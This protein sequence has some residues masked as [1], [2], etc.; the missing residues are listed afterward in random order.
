MYNI[1]SLLQQNK[2]I[3]VLVLIII[4]DILVG[5]FKSIKQ[6]KFNA[7]DGIDGATRKA[8]ELI[9]IVIFIFIDGLFDFN[10]IKFTGLDI[11]SVI[12][13]NKLGLAEFFSIMFTAYELTSVL[14]NLALCGVWLP[15]KVKNSIYEWVENITGEKLTDD[16][17]NKK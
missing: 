17:I 4:L 15:S 6:K 12:G 7:Q 3:S 16:N 5:T 10:L 11:L 2:I 14:K 9:T 8:V 13:I 1:N